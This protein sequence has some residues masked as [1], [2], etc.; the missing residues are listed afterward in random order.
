MAQ[1]AFFLKAFA[2]A[3]AL[4]MAQTADPEQLS[5]LQTLLAGVHQELEMHQGFAKVIG[6]A[7]PNMTCYNHFWSLTTCSWTTNKLRLA[8][9]FLA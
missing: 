1:D 4:A 9:H 8:C 5:T 7:T 6:F 2:Q 3:Y